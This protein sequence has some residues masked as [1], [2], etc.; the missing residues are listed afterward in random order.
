MKMN[1]FFIL[2]SFECNDSVVKNE[3]T[4]KMES[5]RRIKVRDF[6]CRFIRIFFRG[7]RRE[8]RIIYFPHNR[9]T[10]KRDIINE[11]IK[12]KRGRKVELGRRE[13]RGSDK[14]E[15]L[16]FFISID[17]TWG[18]GGTFFF[19]IYLAHGIRWTWTR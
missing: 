10:D 11:K 12:N 13:C 7:G 17:L 1:F 2:F 16:G 4:K 15:G 18:D 5:R 19:S 8:K 6:E 9:H 3:E 14:R